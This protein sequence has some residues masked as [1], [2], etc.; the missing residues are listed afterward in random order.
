MSLLLRSKWKLHN[1]ACFVLA[2][3]FVYKALVYIGTR[4]TNILP[5]GCAGLYL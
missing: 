1:Q 5:E 3:L 2:K 4:D